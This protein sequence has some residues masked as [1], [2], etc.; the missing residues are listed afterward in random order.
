MV[1]NKYNISSK[2]TSVVPQGPVLVPL[3][4]Q[5]FINDLSNGIESLVKLYADVVLASLHLLTIKYYKINLFS[6][7]LFGKCLSI[8]PNVSI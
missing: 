6:G 3:L 7:Q 5:L 2:F 1:D 8:S 4:F